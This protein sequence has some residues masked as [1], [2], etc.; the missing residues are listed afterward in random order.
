M[1]KIYF[2]LGGARSG[3]SSFAEKMAK[4]L[5]EN[6]AYLA[7]SEVI[8]EEMRKRILMHKKRRPATWKTYEIEKKNPESKDIKAVFD[9]ILK[10]NHDVILIDC[11]TILLFR[12]IHK[13]KIDETD[14]IDN[15]LDRQIEKEVKDFFKKFLEVCKNN[16]TF[17]GITSIIVSNEVGQGVVPPYPL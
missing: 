13:F 5:S 11:V 2:L 9:S 15:T 12:I 8:D 6:V 3:K 7:T 4:G 16:A 10:N 17:Y 14:T 1:G